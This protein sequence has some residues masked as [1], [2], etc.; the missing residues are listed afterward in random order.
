MAPD[1]LVHDMRARIDAIDA[2]DIVFSTHF[3]I[4]ALQRGLDLSE[5]KQVLKDTE[6]LV[7]VKE[8]PKRR[9]ALYYDASR[10]RTH[11]FI[12]S[13]KKPGIIVITY[14]L[15][16]QRWQNFMREHSR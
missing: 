4:R 16:Y 9:F 7:F 10:K 11:K 2:K 12:I 5:A 14:M 3:E 15:K 6:H 13:F 8:Q 1:P